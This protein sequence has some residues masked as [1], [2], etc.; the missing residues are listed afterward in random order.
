MTLKTTLKLANAA[1]FSVLMLS[2]P[3]VSAEMLV[4][5][6]PVTSEMLLKRL[7]EGVPDFDNMAMKTDAYR[8]A[9]EFTRHEVAKTEAERLQEQWRSLEDVNSIQFNIRGGIGEYDGA[10]QGFPVR[11]FEPGSYI[12]GGVPYYFSNA[13]EVRIFPVPPE[14]GRETLE[15]FGIGRGAIMTITLTDLKASLTNSGALE[16]RVSEVVF[17]KNDGTKIASYGPPE[18]SDSDSDA[19]EMTADELATSIAETVG[20]P[21]AGTPWG[22]ILPFLKEQPYVTGTGGNFSGELF[23][24]DNGEFKFQ[25]PLDEYPYLVLAFGPN[26]NA[27]KRILRESSR[28]NLGFNGGPKRPFGDLDCFT[29]DVVDQ[30]GL[31]RFEK[32]GE[33]DMLVD[34]MTLAEVSGYRYNDPEIATI[35]DA[36]VLSQMEVAET[37]VAFKEQDFG[38]RGTTA[39][40]TIGAKAYWAGEFNQKGAPLYDLRD[41]YSKSFSAKTMLWL[42]DG[43]KDRTIMATRSS[44]P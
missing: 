42:V 33:H 8:A 32:V 13:S 4:S 9:D 20:I 22:P 23:S 19:P 24:F 40:N 36:G 7:S 2:T 37:Q 41:G 44:L 5:P 1:L 18:R 43:L 21:V 12:S 10:A 34:I 3:A 11:L 16:G 31:M 29:P 38:V 25:R 35:F 26:E 30:C 39:H 6:D 27:A 17:K 14:K 15:K 28:R